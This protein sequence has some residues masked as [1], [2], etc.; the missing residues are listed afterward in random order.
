MDLKDLKDY[1][2]KRYSQFNS[3]ENENEKE[4]IDKSLDNFFNIET[5]LKVFPDA[6]II[7]STRNIHDNIIAI[8]EK[9][10]AKLSWAHT[11]KDILDYIDIYLKIMSYYKKKYPQNIITISLESLND[12][13]NLVTKKIFEF[14]ELNWNEKIFS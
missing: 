2:Y 11:I 4:I 14:C 5:I 7:N 10:L 12:D 6:K 8:Y 3:S 1:L 13:K 9:L